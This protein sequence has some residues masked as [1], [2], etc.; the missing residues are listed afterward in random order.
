[1]NLIDSLLATAER[2]MGLDWTSREPLIA[3]M[4]V[5][6]R[7]TLLQFGVETSRADEVAE[8]L[9]SWFKIQAVGLGRTEAA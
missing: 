6:L 9:V 8:H 1:M 3:S 7:R 2:S 4:K 5:A